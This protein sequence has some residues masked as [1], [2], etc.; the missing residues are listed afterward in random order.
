MKTSH[1]SQFALALQV[2]CLGLEVAV[3]EHR[4]GRQGAQLVCVL[5]QRRHLCLREKKKYKYMLPRFYI[6]V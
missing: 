1:L 2:A 3:G 5:V 4:P 6:H